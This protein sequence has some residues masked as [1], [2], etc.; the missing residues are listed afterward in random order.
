M[1]EAPA[2]RVMLDCERAL[3][4]LVAPGAGGAV[5]ACG[6][7]LARRGRSVRRAPGAGRGEPE[8]PASSPAALGTLALP[9]I[10]PLLL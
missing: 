9:L 3:G 6:R 8:G 4:R 2:I 7:L 10:L 1:A 5:P